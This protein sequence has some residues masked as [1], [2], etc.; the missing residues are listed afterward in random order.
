MQDRR[1]G[2]KQLAQALWRRVAGDD[3]GGQTRA[4]GAQAID[5]F[6]AVL[7]V[8]PVVHHQRVHRA[9]VGEQMRRLD[10]AGR[11]QRGPS[12]LAQIGAQGG[13]YLR[14]IIDHQHRQRV[15]PLCL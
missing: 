12:K 1:A 5:D 14:F 13:H 3:N 2:G 15:A 10:A 6:D 9:A 4:Q 8:Q 11:T 7:F